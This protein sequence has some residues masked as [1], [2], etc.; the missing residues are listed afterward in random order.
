M[1]KEDRDV[2]G[3]SLNAAMSVLKFGKPVDPNAFDLWFGMLS[4]HGISDVTSALTKYTKTNT[5]APTP[6]DILD[7]LLGSL[8]YPDA[9]VAWDRLPKTET[10]GGYMSQEMADAWGDCSDS[11]G[12]GD[13]VAAR[14]SF[15][16][17][18]KSR[19]KKAKQDGV[20]AEFFYSSATGLDHEQRMERKY[21]D[22]LLAIDNGWLNKDSDY[23]KQVLSITKEGMSSCIALEDL[24]KINNSK[25]KQSALKDI[26]ARLNMG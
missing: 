20:K 9:D 4:E 11:L 23:V 8:G 24:S 1:N 14:M 3:R 19:I 12:R 7:I 18:Y 25:I 5:E 13:M 26:R 21:Q 15:I 10:D 6:S 17:S 16:A 22:T 2:F